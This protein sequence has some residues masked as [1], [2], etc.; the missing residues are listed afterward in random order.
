MKEK[1]IFITQYFSLSRDLSMDVCASES[2][3]NFK[4]FPWSLGT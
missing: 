2:N 3:K 4:M 1:K